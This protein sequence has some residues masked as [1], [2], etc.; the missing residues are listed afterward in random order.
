MKWKSYDN[1]RDTYGYR[2]SK[3]IVKIHRP[4]NKHEKIIHFG[5][6]YLFDTNGIHSGCY[7]SS[8]EPRMMIQFEFSSMKSNF[9]GQIGPNQFTL[10]KYAYERLTKYHLIRPGRVSID[11]DGIYVHEGRGRRKQKLKVSEFV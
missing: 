3:K 4:I 10:S 1:S 7:N 6:G 9:P 5:S 8:L 11:V 2:I